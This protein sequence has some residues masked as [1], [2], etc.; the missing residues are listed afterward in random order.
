VPPTGR[1]ARSRNQRVERVIGAR[2]G[3]RAGAGR[4]DQRNRHPRLPRSR[5]PRHG[6]AVFEAG[7][8]PLRLQRLRSHRR[9]QH[10]IQR[11]R[12]AGGPSHRQVPQVGRIKTAT[13]KG[14]PAAGALEPI[15][16]SIVSRHRM[17]QTPAPRPSA[18]IQ[19]PRCAS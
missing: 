2:I 8:R 18:N 15:H 4:I 10:R 14:D 19:L 9:K 12:L 17:A 6:Q 13:K 11:Q 3:S 7:H 5:Q 16:S 1:A